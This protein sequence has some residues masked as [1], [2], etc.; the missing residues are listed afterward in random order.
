[1]KLPVENARENSCEIACENAVET[2]FEPLN[3]A[4]SFD[5]LDL[6]STCISVPNDLPPVNR[7]YTAH[8]Q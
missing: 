8:V 4:T 2:V 7:I 1:M 3:G 6:S 5:T